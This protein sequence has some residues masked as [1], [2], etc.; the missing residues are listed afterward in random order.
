MCATLEL[1]KYRPTEIGLFVAYLLRIGP[2][3][4]PQRWCALHPPRR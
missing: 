4:R 2:I 1:A 3:L